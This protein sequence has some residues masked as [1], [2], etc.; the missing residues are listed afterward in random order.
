MRTYNDLYALALAHLKLLQEQ[1]EFTETA[2]AAFEKALSR[3]KRLRKK[4]LAEEE[5][6]FL[7]P[8]AGSAIRRAES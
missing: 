1:K 4:V 2:E 6:Y 5:I 7:V 8:G 3:T